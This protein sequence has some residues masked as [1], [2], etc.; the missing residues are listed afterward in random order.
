MGISVFADIVVCKCTS[1]VDLSASADGRTLAVVVGLIFELTCSEVSGCVI[2]VLVAI[3]KEAGALADVVEVLSPNALVVVDSWVVSSYVEVK[4]SGVSVAGV[5]LW[6]VEVETI[7]V[8]STDVLIIGTTDVISPAVVPRGV[9]VDVS[10]A[11]VGITKF[12][13]T[14]R[15]KNNCVDGVEP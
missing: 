13:G 3:V 12:S 1:S 5:A 2:G 11:G 4:G 8:D 7:E 9:T 6:G 10:G 15:T 14:N